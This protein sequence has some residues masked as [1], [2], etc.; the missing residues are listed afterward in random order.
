MN[1][2]LTLRSRIEGCLLG[3][4]VG[5]ALGF[6]A[7]PWQDETSRQ[8]FDQDAMG[9]CIPDELNLG[10]VSANTQM[11]LFTAE[12]LS[13]AKARG[14][15]VDLNAVTTTVFQAYLRWLMTQAEVSQ[16]QL[17]SQH[18][19]CSILD[20]VLMGFDVLYKR[21]RPDAV[22][23]QTL[24]QA[25]MGSHLQPVNR[26]K[27]PGAITRVAPVGLVA[28]EATAFELASAVARTTHGHP[29]ACLAA[30]C[31]GHI[32]AGIVRGKR[33]TQMVEAVKIR[34]VQMGDLADECLAGLNR[35]MALLAKG[36][37]SLQKMASLGHG[38][39]AVEVLAIA[40]YCAIAAGN[41]FAKGI[42]MAIRQPGTA[43]H[44]GAVTGALIGVYAGD[45]AI[46]PRFVK[47]LELRALILEMAEDLE[48]I[49]QL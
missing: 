13:I 22:N 12:G 33:I 14:S 45:A 10:A 21:R 43:A 4:A 3:G 20:G 36:P 11:T 49:G 17:V 2:E 23:L 9:P 42:A 44:T 26:S 28:N 25:R 38:E 31:L 8:L 35:A 27:G 47:P 18:G 5:D 29:S 32:I 41:D 40:L 46:P 34:L 24:K 7:Q 39:T 16:N 15:A 6:Q 30:G 37:P 48:R 1:S 19:T